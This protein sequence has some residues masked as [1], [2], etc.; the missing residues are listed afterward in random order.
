MNSM[1]H[2]QKD[3][4]GIPGSWWESNNGQRI[5]LALRDTLSISIGSDRGDFERKHNSFEMLMML[6]PCTFLYT[7][8]VLMVLHVHAKWVRHCNLFT[9][10]H[11]KCTPHPLNS[12]S[13]IWISC[14]QLQLV[15]TCSLQ[16]ESIQSWLWLRVGHNQNI[17]CDICDI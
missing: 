12:I 3:N 7:H 16:M 4:R 17:L 1:R 9:W 5:S 2:V 14:M 8:P 15:C 6:R 13:C 11:Y 10:I